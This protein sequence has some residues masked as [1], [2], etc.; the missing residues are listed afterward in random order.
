[1]DFSTKLGTI[2]STIFIVYVIGLLCLAL[3]VSR[4]EKK[5]G[6]NTEDYFLASKSLPWWAIG[7]SLIA[8]N[9]SAEQ[10][11]GMSGSSGVIYGIRMLQILAERD[12]IET[13]LVMSQAAR[14]SIG[15]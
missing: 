4:N 5:E 15:R 11:I 9:I 10:I 14:M 6:A 8:A 13:H 7:A 1:M 2:D 12:D 3:W